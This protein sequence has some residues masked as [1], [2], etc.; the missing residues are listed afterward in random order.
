MSTFLGPSMDTQL[1]YPMVDSI[2]DVLTAMSDTE[3]R[4]E[5]SE[6]VEA[7][8]MYGDFSSIVGLSNTQGKGLIIFSFSESFSR[9]MVSRLLAINPED[10]SSDDLI[11]GVGEVTNL[12]LGRL[13]TLMNKKNKVE[14]QFSLPEVLIGQEHPVIENEANSDRYIFTFQTDTETFYVQL[15]LEKK[16]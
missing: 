12:I 7:F 14:C 15:R 11:D 16:S 6:Q 13:K 3:T 5:K 9:L 1:L 8:Q 2:L 10:V 4:L